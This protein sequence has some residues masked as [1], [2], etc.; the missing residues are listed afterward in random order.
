MNNKNI[1]VTGAS[2]GIG[3]AIAELLLK[4][5]VNVIGTYNTGFDIANKMEKLHSNLVMHQCNFISKEN[6]GNLIE[7]LGNIPL[8]G[9][10]NNAGVFEMEDFNNFEMELWEKVFQINLNTP[11]QIIMGLKNNLNKSASIVNIS[12]LDGL[13]GA[14]ISMSYSASKAALINLTK[15]LGNNFGKYNI[16]V[17]ALAP[18]WINTGMSTQ[19]SME[20]TKITPLSRNGTPKEVAELV[21]F[22]LSDKASFITGE[23]ITID[24]GYG[25]VDYIMLQ[26]AKN[27]N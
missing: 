2:S 1:L 16:R 15:S 24:G 22:L 3:K 4:Q 27:N 25:N 17:N 6:V 19:E 23:T 21:V 13:V 5:G 14:F 12:S 8:D 18:G 7:T 11:L 26:E 9:I 20:A 10:V